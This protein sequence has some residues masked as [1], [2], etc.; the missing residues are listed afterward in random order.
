MLEYEIK[1]IFVVGRIIDKYN[2]SKLRNSSYYEKYKYMMSFCF[3]QGKNRITNQNLCT[4]EDYGKLILIF[5]AVSNNVDYANVTIFNITEEDLKKRANHFTYFSL[6][7]IISTL[8]LFIS[9]FL[10][11]YEKI[12]LS[13]PQKNE[14]N[15]KLILENQNKNYEMIKSNDIQERGFLY[16]KKAPKWFR[17]LINYIP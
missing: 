10:K 5:N 13:I 4:E 12:K 17:F 8:P 2:Q 3:P 16:R 11:I 9:L 1:P 6:I 14:I 7:V 15:N